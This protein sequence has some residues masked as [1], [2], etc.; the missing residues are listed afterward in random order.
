M[1]G[2]QW[3]YHLTEDEENDRHELHIRLSH[4]RA[5][6]IDLNQGGDIQARVTHDLGYIPR[7]LELAR[8]F[9]YRLIGPRKKAEWIT[10]QR[11]QD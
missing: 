7:L 10:A 6:V 11:S 3:Q 4:G 5:M 8:L 1:K 2:T 9:P